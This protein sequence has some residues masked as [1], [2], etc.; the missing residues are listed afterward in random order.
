M[1]ILPCMLIW[2]VSSLFM[3][4]TVNMDST[5]FRD[6]MHDTIVQIWA[7]QIF[8]F[9]EIT[10]E[11]G[12]DDS[13]CSP[14]VLFSRTTINVCI[15]WSPSS[16]GICWKCRTGSICSNVWFS[17]GGCGESFPQLQYDRKTEIFIFFLKGEWKKD[18]QLLFFK[19][20]FWYCSFI[21]VREKWYRPRVWNLCHSTCHSSHFL[22]VRFGWHM[23]C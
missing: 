12:H 20:C 4:L 18:Y 21:Y 7:W 15:P 23:D 14:G 8:S 11:G 10:E 22:Q 1:W 13:T 16:Q 17:T 5:E 6:Y 2:K 3:N 19:L 9:N